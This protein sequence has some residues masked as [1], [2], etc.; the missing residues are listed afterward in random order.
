MSYRLIDKTLIK[1]DAE[2]NN[3]S[4]QKN[5][6]ANKPKNAT[7]NPPHKQEEVDNIKHR[8]QNLIRNQHPH[9]YFLKTLGKLGV[10]EH[11]RNLYGINYA[12]FSKLYFY[13]VIIL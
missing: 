6:H 4:T 8:T 3:N 7:T 12:K 5:L 1:N 10:L 11:V 13:R 9:R 2:P